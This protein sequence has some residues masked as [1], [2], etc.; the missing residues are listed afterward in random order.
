MN[1]DRS[2]Q[3]QSDE[4]G[5]PV[6]FIRIASEIAEA[7]LRSRWGFGAFRK[8]DGVF[9]DSIDIVLQSSYFSLRPLDGP[10]PILVYDPKFWHFL[11]WR[12]WMTPRTFIGNV[13]TSPASY[14]PA[15]VWALF[16]ALAKAEHEFLQRYVPYWSHEERLTG[17][18][19]SQLIERLEGFA[20]HW[21]ALNAEPAKESLCRIWYA[22]T[23]A[24]RKEGVTGADLG[25]IIQARLGTQE[26]FFKAARFQSKKVRR[27]GDARIDLNQ[28][29]AL[30]HPQRLGYYVFYHP[31]DKNSW[32]LAPTVRPATDFQDDLKQAQQQNPPRQLG[33]ITKSVNRNGVDLAMFVTFALADAGA[34]HGVLAST[35]VEAAS[36]LMSGDPRPSRVLVVTLGEVTT[37]VEWNTVLR[38]WIGSQ[39]LE[40]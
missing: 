35:A 34:D 37:P 28:V 26:E 8:F 21:R 13:L 23:A 11:G 14:N 18:L 22:D 30:L 27:S 17:H 39:F 15:P 4:S 12:H 36:V 9:R 24:A 31:L 32:S 5:G 16:W 10:W 2:I 33:E 40:E 19:V 25:L 29:K 3:A 7:P 20:P 38:E 1:Q 6:D